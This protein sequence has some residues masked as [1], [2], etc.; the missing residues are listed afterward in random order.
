[1]HNGYCSTSKIWQSYTNDARQVDQD[2]PLQTWSFYGHWYHVVRHGLTIANLK[3]N[4]YVKLYFYFQ[5]IFTPVSP[6]W[7]SWPRPPFGDRPGQTLWW[8]QILCWSLWTVR[9]GRDPRSTW[10]EIIKRVLQGL[11]A[12]RSEPVPRFQNCNRL[13][14]GDRG[15]T[16]LET[17]FQTGQIRPKICHFGQFWPKFFGQSP[18]SDWTLAEINHNYCAVVLATSPTRLVGLVA[19][20]KQPHDRFPICLITLF[21]LIYH[22]ASVWGKNLVNP[23]DSNSSQACMPRRIPSIGMGSGHVSPR[24]GQKKI[25]KLWKSCLS[26]ISNRSMTGSKITTGPPNR[27]ISGVVVFCTTLF[28]SLKKDCLFFIRYHLP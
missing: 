18:N 20:L 2:H 8:G 25:K 5:D 4:K 11:Q 13:Q 7:A 23:I 16:I 1:M 22:E 10:P 24:L 19:K 9:C 14:N 17:R 12:V 3:R 15:P 6:I 27:A 21:L 26:K 28:F